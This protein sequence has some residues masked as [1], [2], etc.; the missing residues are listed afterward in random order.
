MDNLPSAP[1]SVGWSC[2][3]GVSA[4][5]FMTSVCCLGKIIVSQ[6][7]VVTH[8]I[9]R[10]LKKAAASGNYYSAQMLPGNMLMS[11]GPLS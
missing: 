3:R 1:G 8:H 7:Q 5:I 2:Y 9:R 6:P 11:L 10:D 4:V